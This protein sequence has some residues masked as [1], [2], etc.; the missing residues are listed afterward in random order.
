MLTVVN[1]TESVRKR[2]RAAYSYCACG[3]LQIALALPAFASMKD[4]HQGRV[5]MGGNII[6]SACAI[7][8]DS[9]QQTLTLKEAS[10]DRFIKLGQGELHPFRIKLLNCSPAKKDGDKWVAFDITFHGIPDGENFALS[11]DS[12]GM[13]IEIQDDR[14]FVARPGVAMPMHPVPEGEKSLS[15]F[16]RLVGN[17]KLLRG[18]SHFASLNYKLDYY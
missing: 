2:M 13:A 7:H 1:C 3:I 4:T 16:V 6:E 15:Y 14:G 8:P 12:Q 9:H 5:S 10:A 17:A 18:G 11:G